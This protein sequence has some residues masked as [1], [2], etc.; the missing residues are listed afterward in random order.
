MCSYS[1]W[2]IKLAMKFLPLD[3]DSH[4]CQKIEFAL[5]KYCLLY[6]VLFQTFKS[7]NVVLKRILKNEEKLRRDCLKCSPRWGTYPGVYSQLIIVFT[8]NTSFCEFWKLL[9]RFCIPDS[10]PPHP[11]LKIFVSCIMY[12]I[13]YTNET[14]FYIEGIGRW[15]TS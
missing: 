5:C 11:L 7:F 10:F 4:F 2:K 15:L 13:L 14:L 1:A 3:N 8:G 12:E 6:E 9:C